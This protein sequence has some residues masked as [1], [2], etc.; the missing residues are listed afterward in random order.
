M[1]KDFSRL[2]QCALLMCAF[3]VSAAT[4][5][6]AP[7]IIYISPN[8]DGVQDILTVPLHIQDK[9]Y[10]SEWSL[11][12][13]DESGNTVRTIGN[14][15][16]RP[17]KLTPK[18]L[19]QIL[20]TPKQGVAVPNSVSWDGVLESGEAAP[21]GT[22][23]YYFIAVD[24][25]GNRQETEHSRYR[26][27]VD[28]TPPEINLTQPREA[29]KFFG[30]G[31]KSTLIITQSGSAED[32]WTGTM[33]DTAGNTVKTF[34]WA[35]GSPETAIWDGKDNDG[36]PVADGVYAY[37][38][39]S[40]DRAG[41]KS[42]VTRVTNIVYSADR[43]AASI[44]INGSR[45]FSPNGDGVQDTVAFTVSIPAPATGNR[46]AKWQVTVQDT[47]GVARKTWTGTNTPPAQLSYNGTNDDGVPLREGEY[48]AVVSATY[49]NG[50]E[51]DP[52]RSPVFVL[53]VT[54][55]TARVQLPRDTI[56]GDKNKATISIAVQ[57]ASQERAWSAEIRNSANAVVRQ[58]TFGSQPDSSI[59]WNGLT[60]AGSLAPDGS[61]VCR[62]FASDQ[63]GNSFEASTAAFTLDTS[64]TEAI[65]TVQPQAFS[66]NNDRVQD[67]IAFTPVVRSASG[68]ASYTL[69]VKNASGAEVRRF[70]AE[71]SLPASIPWNGMTDNGS[72]CPDGRYTAVLTAVSRNGSQT[73]AETQAF[74]LDTVFPSVTVSAAYTLFS[75][76]GDTFKD[77]LPLS[78]VTSV[79]KR[80]TGTITASGGANN[81]RVIREF[82]WQDGAAVSFEWDGTDESGNV[83]PDGA[84]RF[85]LTSQDAAGNRSSAEVTGITVDNRPTRAYLTAEVEAFSPA[86]TKAKQQNIPITLSLKD[87]IE[88]WNFDIVPADMGAAPVRSWS[89]V[90][91]GAIPPAILWDG[92]TTTGGD[93]N[94]QFTGILSVVYAKGNHVRSETTPF[95]C[96]STPPQ[97][98]VTTA[99]QYFSPDNDGVDDD[100]FISLSGKSLLSFDSW[101][102]AVRDPQNGKP[103]WTVTGK[104]AITE[105][106]TW[107]G[108]GNNGELVQSAMDYPYTFTVTD[109]QGMTSSVEG[110]IPVDVLVIRDGNLL[111]MRVPA[112]V[113]QSNAATL[114]TAGPGLT[115]AQVANNKRVLDRI[116]E[117]LKKFADYNV[118]IEGH[119]NNVTGN[120]TTVDQEGIELS[121]K[122]AEAVRAYL[123]GKGTRAARLSTVG[124]G[125]T[126]P[127]VPFAD[128]DNW[129]KNRRV[130]F[131][132]NK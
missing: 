51:S 65:V 13:A 41:N 112:I 121:R 44:A 24:D 79:E 108:K 131:I 38:I 84:Y 68:V 34:T 54:P 70:S 107:A 103:F 55:P 126:V 119:S 91:G 19:W 4:L 48:Q 93:A 60:D 33:Q 117:I 56:F 25:N 72:P 118:T 113:F 77:T 100:L 76:D 15:E 29:D 127:V 92:K 86:G 109:T 81:N 69:S 62:V 22:Y 94:G 6:A 98:G 14:K 74:E 116:A 20:T 99:P 36:V 66:P 10:I 16:K 43:P 75:P 27:V 104:S 58:Y 97:L 52:A 59:T 105:R 45:Y 47:D 42:S 64:A 89:S 115:D 32:K 26:V 35:N 128:R 53:D 82:S 63:A 3:F 114:D 88:S 120:R 78:I 67:T 2:F 46:L 90:G 73:S 17:E 31:M 129:W 106:L 18:V 61:Y 83:V 132:L 23:S 49:L 101:S 125:D 123:V 30:E 11:V 80:W 130:E 21:D 50:F 57:N 8:N 95:I 111:R 110:V 9:R 71:S 37:S 102:F 96:T 12:I 122:R 87:G 40:I 7:E 28:N 85:T 5:F 1:K 39:E 124:K